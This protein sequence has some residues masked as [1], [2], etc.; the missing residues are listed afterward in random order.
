MS[1]IRGVWDGPFKT[2]PQEPITV[3]WA[4]LKLFET[5]W[6]LLLIV[7]ALIALVVLYV[8]QSERNP[9]SSQ[10]GIQL[11]P[12]TSYCRSRGWPINALIENNSRKVIGELGLKFRVYPQGSSTDVVA[13]D[14]VQ[15]D[16]HNILRPGEVLD[17]C[18]PMPQLQAGS[19]GPYTVALDVSY[20]S[21]LSKDIPVTSRPQ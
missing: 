17:W 10:I 15:P 13:Y 5:L 1:W 7:I 3:G 21:E 12:A 14:Y 8:W 11:S 16:M 18:F 20:A 19:K 4:L 9:L 2:P 6:R